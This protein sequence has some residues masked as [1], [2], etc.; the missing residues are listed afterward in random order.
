[1]INLPQINSLQLIQNYS[2]TRVVMLKSLNLLCSL[3]SPWRPVVS[4]KGTIASLL[5]DRDLTLT[6]GSD[7]VAVADAVPVLSVLFTP[8]LALE[9]HAT[10]V[11]AKYFYQLRQLRRVRRLLDPDS[12]TILV[13]AFVISRIDYGNSLFAFANAP[14][15]WTDRLQRVMN[16]A[17]GVYPKGVGRALAISHIFEKGVDGLVIWVTYF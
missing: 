6:I 13:H 14:K 8:D 11:S 16:A 10:S 12:A 5:H 4:Q 2:L 1:M 7:T 3:T 15:I 9:K 17:R